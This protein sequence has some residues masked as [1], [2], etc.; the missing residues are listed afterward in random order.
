MSEEQ[1]ILDRLANHSDEPISEATPIPIRVE[2]SKHEAT[3]SLRQ[4][5]AAA[6]EN[7]EIVREYEERYY[8]SVETRRK[9]MRAEE[10][11]GEVKHKLE[12][13][14][15]QPHAYATQGLSEE[16]KGWSA[17][18]HASFLL[19]LGVGTITGGLGA[20]LLLFAPL[21]IYYSFRDRSRFVA[22]QAMQ[23]FALQVIATVGWL[24][25]LI[26]GSIVFVLAL[27]ISGLA[28]IVLIGIPFLILFAVLFVVFLLVMIFVPLGMATFSIIAAINT[29]LGKDYRYPL[30]A[31]WLDRQVASGEHIL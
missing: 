4:A 18:A 17:L 7:D 24:G 20:L 26:A 31:K 16:E 21:A 3:D 25:V 27:V 6:R 29:Y 15:W 8:G 1:N 22:Y 11:A 14:D 13:L 10:L 9:R 12:G 5:E 30:I 28:G 23:A 2:K 19:T